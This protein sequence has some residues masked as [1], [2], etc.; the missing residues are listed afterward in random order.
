[1]EGYILGRAGQIQARLHLI[2]GAVIVGIEEPLD[3]RQ[4]RPA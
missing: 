2:A 3:P 1:M 4:V